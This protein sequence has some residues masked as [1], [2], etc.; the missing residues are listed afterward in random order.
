MKL[1]EEFKEYETMWESSINE[2][3]SP[4]TRMYTLPDGS[5]INLIDHQACVAEKE[6]LKTIEREL[7]D[8]SKIKEVNYYYDD[9]SVGHVPSILMKILQCF[10]RLENDNETTPDNDKIISKLKN[11]TNIADKVD[12]EDIRR[13]LNAG[14][15]AVINRRTQREI[16]RLADELRAIYERLGLVK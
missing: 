1:H 8:Q 5:E 9:L 6:R 15:K 13:Q 2:D 14:S 11:Y 3:A 12:L 4:K 10:Y 16:E 7:V